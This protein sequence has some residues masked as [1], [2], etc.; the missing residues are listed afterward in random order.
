MNL[1]CGVILPFSPG[2]RKVDPPLPA[3]TPRLNCGI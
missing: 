1:P 3:T 2:E